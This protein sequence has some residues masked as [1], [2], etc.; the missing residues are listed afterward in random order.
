MLMNKDL[1]NLVVIDKQK[2][3]NNIR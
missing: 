2:A 3:V 1:E